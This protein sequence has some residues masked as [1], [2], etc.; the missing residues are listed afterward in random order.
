MK[1]IILCD[2]ETDKYGSLFLKIR[3]KAYIYRIHGYNY[4]DIT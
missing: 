4:Q 3:L 2:K 1:L